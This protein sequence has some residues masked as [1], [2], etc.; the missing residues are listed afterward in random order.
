MLKFFT[1]GTF[2]FLLA[3]CSALQPNEE[4]FELAPGVRMLF[5]EV[6]C[7]KPSDL[8]QL[9]TVTYEGKTN[10]LLTTLSCSG[11][12][13]YFDAF[14]PLGARAFSLKKEG[15]TL[16][17]QVPMPTASNSHAEE[18]LG[19]LLLSFASSEEIRKALPDRFV[20]K[21]ENLR[22]IVLNPEG[23]EIKK[24]VYSKGNVPSS[25]EDF[26]FGYIIK[27]KTLQ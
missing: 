9:L 17:A 25:I 1:V 11:K 16:S 2:C 23:K 7:P 3:G 26:S 8:K 6:T 20:L 10:V 27:I 19:D 15:K 4:S 14:L 18:V 21:E 12:N 13:L 22:R 5:P 24:I